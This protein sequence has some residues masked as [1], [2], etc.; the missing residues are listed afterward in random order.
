MGTDI[1]A[2]SQ[3]ER[4]V[5]MLM[6][7]DA[8]SKTQQTALASVLLAMTK[9]VS[10]VADIKQGLWQPSALRDM[11]D[12]RHRSLCASCPVKQAHEATKRAE[13]PGKKGVLAQILS[14][15]VMIFIMAILSL[16]TAM[17]TIIGRQGVQDV[18]EIVNPIINH[19]K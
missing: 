19:S 18:S 6:Q 17:Y 2:E 15:T 3:T 8:D 16:L 11:I 5:N 12:E 14:P 10:E 9:L 1:I 7:G 13:E 4:T